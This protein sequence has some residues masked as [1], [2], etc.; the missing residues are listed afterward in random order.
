MSHETPIKLNL[1]C[2]LQCPE[3]WINIDSSLGARLARRPLLKKFLHTVVPESWGVLPNHEW[4]GN[5]K[6]MNIT[7]RFDYE[8]NSVDAVYSSHTIE[9]LTYNE[10]AFVFSET[11]RVL[12]PGGIIRIIVPDFAQTVNNYLNN[13]K[14]APHL[15]AKNFLND[16]FY[17][18][19]P[20]PHSLPGLVKYYFKRKNNHHFLYDEE[21]LRYQLSNAGFTDV[22]SMQWGASRI[23]G[24]E[25]ID[26]PERFRGAICLEGI[27]P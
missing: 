13:R 2:G 12:Q 8:D 24:I 11:F 27:K 21:G 4:S 18:E 10:A 5:V 16:T 26:I 22:C 20:I 1:G 14:Q 23:S 15:A 6:W 25:K 3:G 17:F 7:R 19:I 9:H